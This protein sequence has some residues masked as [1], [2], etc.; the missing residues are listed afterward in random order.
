MNIKEA[1]R[2]FIKNHSLGNKTIA[3]L[4]RIAKDRGI[5]VY[6]DKAQILQCITQSE[7]MTKLFRLNRKKEIKNA[8]S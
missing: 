2:H 6:G 4:K 3:E 8:L 1:K 7:H 5:C